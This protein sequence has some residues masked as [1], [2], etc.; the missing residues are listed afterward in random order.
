LETISNLYFAL[1]YDIGTVASQPLA[2]S[3]PGHAVGVGVRYR[4]PIG[5]LRLDFAVNPGPRFAAEKSWAVHFSV[6][7]GF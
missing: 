3:E 7:S 6:G 4:T 1:F 5:P 2:L